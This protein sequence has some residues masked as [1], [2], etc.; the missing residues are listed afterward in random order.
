ML[1]VYP[2]V[3]K[4]IKVHVADMSHVSVP[5][6]WLR[7]IVEKPFGTD[8]ESSNELAKTLGAL[9]PEDKLYR[10]D[11]YLGKEL[12]QNMVFMRF[13][14]IMFSGIWNKEHISNVQITF[15]EPF[16]T[17]GRGGYFDS[18]GIIRDVIQNHLL[19][20]RRRALP[21]LSIAL[22]AGVGWLTRMIDACRCWRC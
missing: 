12:S 9:W 7:L 13:T 17:D 14:N 3:C 2:E 8:L 4:G 19:Q 15:K 20:V 16:G 1:Q 18:V 21:V 22:P 6:S 11:H 5:G 10:I